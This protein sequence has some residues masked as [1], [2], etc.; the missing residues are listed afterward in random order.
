M[1]KTCERFV[2]D[3]LMHLINEKIDKRQFGS[4]KKSSQTHALFSLIHHLLNETDALKNFV[5]IFVVDCS[6]AFDHIDHNILLNK[7][8]D[9]DVLPTITTWI[10]SFLTTRSQRVKISH[11]V[12]EWQTLN[13]GVP[14]GTV[15]GPILFLIMVNDLLTDWKD[16]WKYVDFTTTTETIGPDYNSKLQDLV[17]CIDSW[18]KNNNMKLNVRKCK[19]LIIDLTKISSTFHL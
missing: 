19:E 7:L 16:R 9:L 17:D 13:G 8:F 3:W 2:A 18:I 4:L 10:R 12:S 11:C 5:R 1:S 14:Q 6:K 15:L